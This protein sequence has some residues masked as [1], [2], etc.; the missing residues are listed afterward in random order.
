MA[1]ERKKTRKKHRIQGVRLLIVLLIIAVAVTVTAL[2]GFTAFALEDVDV[3][4][5]EIYS[6]EQI[7]DGVL[8]E[9]YAWNT[10]YILLGNRF[11][12]QEDIP[13]VDGME[14]HMVSPHEIRV[15]VTEKG[16]LGYIYIPMLKQNAYFDQDGFVV[17]LSNEEVEGVSRIYGLQVE[18]AELYKKLELEDES[19]LKTLLTLT[20]LL[21]KYDCEPDLIYIDGNDILLYY[22]ELQVNLGTGNQLS[23]KVLRMQEV[24]PELEGQ[25]GTLHLDSWTDMD[26]D[27]YF[28]PDEHT[29]IPVDTQTLS[30]EVVDEN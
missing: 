7:E 24:L 12:R 10:L 8:K 29:E 4:G 14:V 26:T 5:N 21:R 2:V 25:S 13:F 23:E 18:S 22:G 3:V 16:V 1:G 19:I 11:R 15:D 30:A 6:D 27:F 20:Q 9:D 17:E 28:T